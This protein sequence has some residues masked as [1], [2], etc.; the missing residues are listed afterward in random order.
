MFYTAM[1]CTL[2]VPSCVIMLW[3]T[4]EIIITTAII[5]AVYTIIFSIKNATRIAILIFISCQMRLPFFF[6]VVHCYFPVEV[7]DVYLFRQGKG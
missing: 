5:I 3:M 6:T 2:G 4:K 1:L 7:M